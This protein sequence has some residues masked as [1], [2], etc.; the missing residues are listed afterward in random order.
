MHLAQINVARFRAPLDDPQLADFVAQL[1]SIN[2]L[3]ERSD[4]FVW[5]LT[6][7]AGTPSSYIK[8]SDDDLTIVNMS[9]WT[10]IDALFDSD[11]RGVYV[12]SPVCRRARRLVAGRA[13]TSP[14]ARRLS[15]GAG[16]C[17]K[18]V[19]GSV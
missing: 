17:V 6:S 15:G 1:D 3:A 18:V 13:K 14:R 16:R 19:F 5:R 10:S 11:A 8:F 4:G 7:E 9:A 12:Q 2:A